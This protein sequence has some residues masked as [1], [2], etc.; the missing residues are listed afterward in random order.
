[1]YL[2]SQKIFRFTGYR[3]RCP[4]RDD[5]VYI[6]HRRLA[7]IRVTVPCSAVLPRKAVCRLAVLHDG[8]DA[9]IIIRRH[10]VVVCGFRF[11]LGVIG[12]FFLPFRQ[13]T[14]QAVYPC[15]VRIVLLAIDRRILDAC[16]TDFF[17]Q[18]G[19]LVFQSPDLCF[20]C[21][22]FGIRLA[23]HRIQLREVKVVFRDRSLHGALLGVGVQCAAALAAFVLGGA[24]SERHSV[25]TGHADGHALASFQFGGVCRLIIIPRTGGYIVGIAVLILVELRKPHVQLRPKRVQVHRVGI[26]D[27]LIDYLFLVPALAH[28]DF[29]C[30]C[31]LGLL[32]F[33]AD[34]QPAWFSEL[35]STC[36]RCEALG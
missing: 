26:E 35:A 34:D 16:R 21:G 4:E 10:A 9:V 7:Y 8:R 25:G 3:D 28:M 1:M 6:R 33:L 30:V 18:Y 27:I 31:F 29:V 15:L 24:L 13:F 17:Q 11:C 32:V 14:F 36:S 22:D 5:T 2:D 19:V 23:Q 12:L 20:K